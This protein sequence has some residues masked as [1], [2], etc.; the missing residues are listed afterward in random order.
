L[1]H[2][3]FCLESAKSPGE[4]DAIKV[5]LKNAPII[6]ATLRVE[7]ISKT[8]PIKRAVEIIRHFFYLAASL[9]KRDW[10]SWPAISC[11][12]EEKCKK[13]VAGTSN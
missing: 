10:F 12:E 3:C 8:F 7:R 13:A 5:L 2:L 4:K 9:G 11:P 6:L 1:E